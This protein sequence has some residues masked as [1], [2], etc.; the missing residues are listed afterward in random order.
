MSILWID[1]IL[2][3]KVENYFPKRL[4]KNVKNVSQFFR[5][6]KYINEHFGEFDTVVL[7]VNFEKGFGGDESSGNTIEE[8]S[9]SDIYKYINLINKENDHFTK[10]AG[11]YLYIYLISKGFPS[12][13]IAMLTANKERKNENS[14]IK[15][16]DY[17]I[18]EEY[19]ANSDRSSLRNLKRERPEYGEVITDIIGELENKDKALE[20]LNGDRANNVN[21]YNIT[22]SAEEWEKV[23]SKAGIVAPKSFSKSSNDMDTFK[24]WISSMYNSENEY[25]RIRSIVYE[26]CNYWEEKIDNPNKDSQRADNLLEYNN[27]V[28][29]PSKKLTFSDVEE[30]LRLVKSSFTL[31]KPSVVEETYFQV[32]RSLSIYFDVKMNYS[33][34]DKYTGIFYNIMELFRN[35][36]SHN[37][38]N[39]LPKAEEFIFTFIIA[40]RS[41][42][43]IDNELLDYERKAVELLLIR[44]DEIKL[45]DINIRK[46]IEK[47]LFSSIHDLSHKSK[48]ISRYAN[49]LLSEIGRNK[50]LECYYEYLFRLF[51]H[52][53]YPTKL[54]FKEQ[55]R[56]VTMDFYVK[57]ID[58]Q[59]IKLLLEGTFYLTF[60][61]VESSEK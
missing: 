1:D 12:K 4:C 2:K 31:Y 21:T 6:V 36:S 13:R 15:G 32:L 48:F 41:Y 26:A 52:G 61:N 40:L 54:K 17:K 29:D 35:W 11:Y 25:Y 45:S 5:A 49:D 43:R 9:D 8:N 22:Q 55:Q 34:K 27:M 38:F 53:I 42:F 47:T 10:N 50:K 3:E 56:Y 39:T 28:F 18:I 24:E 51:W 20:I 16:E 19:I 46:D 57:D 59:F 44:N 37:K 60:K 33:G 30:I 58:D 14:N 23:F 7:D